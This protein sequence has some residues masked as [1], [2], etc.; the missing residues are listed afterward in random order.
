MPAL[1][2]PDDT[3]RLPLPPRQA[4]LGGE[5]DVL[6]VGGG[7]AGLG[8]A[9]AAA[10]AGARVVLA[11]RYGFLGG[12][13]TAALVMP[14]MSFHTQMPTAEKKGATTLLPTDHGPGDAVVHG[15]L[16]APARAPGA[17]RRRHCA[18][19]GDR[20]HGA[21]RSRMVQ[22]D[23]ARAPRR[24][25][26]RVP[27]PC[28]RERRAAAQRGRGLRD[29]VRAACDPRQGHRRLHGRWRRRGA[30]GRALRGRPRRR[31]GPAD[32]ADVPRHRVPARGIRELRARQ[33]EGM[34]RRARAVGA[35]APG[36]RGGRA[37][38]AAR[39]HAL[40]RHAA[41]R[42]RSASTAPA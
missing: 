26:G 31:A 10:D 4:L 29:E 33:P 5:T 14:L 20:L 37:Q 13:A 3:V 18:F 2:R 15:V 35:G 22:A 23:R 42:T 9:I 7:P 17:R 30:G 25:G 24:S 41:R 39:G 16:G 21:V 8:A 40:F 32:D 27:V 6:V 12:N 34:A 1:K 19:A 38:P 36:G 28:V 11:E